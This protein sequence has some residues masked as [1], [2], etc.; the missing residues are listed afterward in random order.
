MLYFFNIANKKVNI[1]SYDE[2]VEYAQENV[3]KDIVTAQPCPLRLQFISEQN[4]S[5]KG[6]ILQ[7]G[8]FCYTV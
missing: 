4:L 6:F 5:I 7:E 8:F 2:F 1:I 3:I